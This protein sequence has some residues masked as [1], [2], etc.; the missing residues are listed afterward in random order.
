MVRRSSLLHA[1]VA[2]L[3]VF[4]AACATGVHA[5]PSSPRS[6]SRPVADTTSG[7]PNRAAADSA[8][9]VA[10][11]SRPVAATDSMRLPRGGDAGAWKP[12]PVRLGIEWSPG[13]LREGTA[14]AV[15]LLLPA[16]ASPPVRVEG[17]HAGHSVPFARVGRSWLGFVPLPLGRSGADTLSLSTSWSEGEVTEQSLVLVVEGRV[18]P[19]T[20]LRVAPRFSS[21]PPEAATRIERERE[22][23]RRLLAQ[24]TEAWLPR[25]DFEAPR[26]WEV[27]SP[28]GQRRLFNGEL[29]SRHTGL[30][31]AGREGEPVRA[32]ARGRVVLTADRYYTG[33]SVY[34]DHGL[35]VYT[36]YFHL[37]RIDVEANHVVEAGE[38]IGRI[39]ATGRVTGPHLHWSLYVGGQS[40]DAASLLEMSLPTDGPTDL[41]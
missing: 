29:R 27:T 38:V 41:P 33:G 15:K 37:S 8:A 39:G 34:V 32:S 6:D 25:G 2:L 35:G 24:V 30:D 11:E 17:R 7:T 13:R 18:F 40:L 36:G 28:F 14:A 21:P 4:P 5:P 22:E 12:P 26:P 16:G 1:L 23:V 3:T 19:S 10:T 20:N 9:S 31:L